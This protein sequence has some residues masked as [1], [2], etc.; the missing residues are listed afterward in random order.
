MTEES[1][2]R[3]DEYRE[4]KF[5]FQAGY[6]G[7]DFKTKYGCDPDSLAVKRGYRDGQECSEGLG[8]PDWANAK[9]PRH[10]AREVGFEAPWPGQELD[11]AGSALDR[12]LFP[13]SDLT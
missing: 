10:Y 11:L 4:Y 13:D 1:K 12:E 9:L 7:E 8:G 2:L 3:P 6:S 5:G